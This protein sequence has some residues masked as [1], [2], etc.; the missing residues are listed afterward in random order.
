MIPTSETLEIS[1]PVHTQDASSKRWDKGGV[2]VEI[3]PNRDYRIK[4]PSVRLY[5][6][7]SLIFAKGL[8]HRS[9]TNTSNAVGEHAPEEDNCLVRF[10]SQAAPRRSART[11][12]PCNRFITQFLSTYLQV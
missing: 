8:H 1:F 5:Y 9:R 2:I 4:L 6:E 3:G 11:K 7:K 10:A 12:K